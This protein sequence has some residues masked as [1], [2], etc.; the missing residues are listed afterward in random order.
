[1]NIKNTI[2]CLAGLFS[3]TSYAA[4]FNRPFVDRVQLIDESYCEDLSALEA[5]VRLDWAEKNDILPINIIDNHRYT[6]VRVDGVPE[7]IER[8]NPQYPIFGAFEDNGV[9][10]RF[11]TPGYNEEK[12]PEPYVWLL[13]CSSLWFG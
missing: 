7:L 3:F 6:S 2:L 4:Q 13:S 8:E 1:M 10:I 9:D 11:W 12:V 5:N